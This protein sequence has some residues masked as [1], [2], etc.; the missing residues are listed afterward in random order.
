MKTRVSCASP[1]CLHHHMHTSRALVPL[2]T[3]HR[4]LSGVILSLSRDTS[5]TAN[6]I[7]ADF[8]RIDAKIDRTVRATG[9]GCPPG[10]GKCC[11]SPTVDSSE[12]ELLPL[13]LELIRQGKA[14]SVL[15]RLA[16]AKQ[17]GDPTCVLFQRTV[18]DGSLGRCGMYEH[19]PGLCRLYGF[20]G[21]R[22]ETGEREWRPCSHMRAMKPEMEAALREPP[23]ECMPVIAD[24]LRHLRSSYG[25]PSDQAPIPINEAL[26]RAISRQLTKAMYSQYADDD[27]D[28]GVAPSSP[29]I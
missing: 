1:H 16:A 26:S 27:D 22:Y 23:P 3:S 21:A 11:T 29:A 14:E 5:T 12:A 2:C 7:M 8:A 18:P 24:E 25:S 15:E 4:L 10:C 19:R 17:N 20:S 6:S 9:I 28:A 13:A